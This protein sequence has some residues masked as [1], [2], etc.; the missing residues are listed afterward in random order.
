MLS[1]TETRE[2]AILSEFE[3][4]VTWSDQLHTE[5]SR[6]RSRAVSSS[7]AAVPRELSALLQ[8]VV[9]YYSL[10]LASSYVAARSE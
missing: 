1:D 5:E 4:E 2:K 6:R 3:I 10:S 8:S 9:K 7:E